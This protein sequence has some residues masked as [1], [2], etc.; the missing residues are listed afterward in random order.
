MRKLGIKGD[1]RP[2]DEGG[3]APQMEGGLEQRQLQRVDQPVGLCLGHDH[4]IAA[5]AHQPLQ[6]LLVTLEFMFV[7]LTGAI[8]IR[9]I[10]G[11]RQHVD[12]LVLQIRHIPD[13]QLRMGDDEDLILGRKRRLAQ[14]DQKFLPFRSPVGPQ[15]QI[16]LAM[17]QHLKGALEGDADKLDLESSL[18]G[19]QFQQLDVVTRVVGGI[20]D[21]VGW[22]VV[23]DYA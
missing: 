3:G 22:R 2:G 13:Q 23:D 20:Y 21:A 8:D 6:P 17:L 11:A 9:V 19:P 12:P 10:D 7:K 4:H 14:K 5:I 16:R 1:S 18:G 15:Q